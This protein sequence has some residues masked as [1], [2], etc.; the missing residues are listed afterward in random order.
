MDPE[1]LGA[2]V[3]SR[4]CCSARWAIPKRL[5]A[6]LVVDQ[7]DRNIVR[8]GQSVDIKLEGFP[9]TTLHSQIAEIAESELKVTPAAALDQVGRRSCP[10]RPIRTPASRRR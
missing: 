7:A 10:P 1:N 6:V 2:H 5:E 8:E 4:A 3:W 9:A